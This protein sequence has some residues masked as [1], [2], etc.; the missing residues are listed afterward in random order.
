ML[1]LDTLLDAKASTL[2]YAQQHWLEVCMA[3]GTNPRVVLM[4]E[5]TAGMT[6]DE[7]AATAHFAQAV[8]AR[9]I[10]ILVIEH[11]MS[12]VR[13]INSGITVLHQGNVFREGS[14]RQIEH[15]PDVQ[16]IYL[17]EENVGSSI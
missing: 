16:R 7:T 10:A 1:G 2:S 17:G 9:G 3:I 11:D 5:P 13:E 4:D 6:P 14:V 15:D 8:C 12:F